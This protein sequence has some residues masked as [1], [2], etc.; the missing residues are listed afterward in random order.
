MDSL[1]LIQCGVVSIANCQTANQRNSKLSL[2]TW[3]TKIV[4]VLRLF[5]CGTKIHPFFHYFLFFIFYH[6]FSSNIIIRPT[7]SITDN[8]LRLGI[9][10]WFLTFSFEKARM[11]LPRLAVSSD[12]IDI[13]CK[14]C[15]HVWSCDDSTPALLKGPSKAILNKVQQR[16][17]LLQSYKDNEFDS[18]HFH[19]EP[20]SVTRTSLISFVR[21][22]WIIHYLSATIIY[23]FSL[24]RKQLWIQ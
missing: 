9:N 1:K 13:L 18:Q 7:Q 16:I 6:H 3:S 19:F 15:E 4:P 14:P 8:V 17:I 23:F 12:N 5:V 11:S 21:K 10:S 20:S 24:N 22:P 2:N